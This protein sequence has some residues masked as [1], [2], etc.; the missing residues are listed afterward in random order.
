VLSRERGEVP[1]LLEVF[2]C[3]GRLVLPVLPQ[4]ASRRRISLI[5][6]KGDRLES[7]SSQLGLTSGACI[8]SQGT[9]RMHILSHPN[10]LR[11]HPGTHSTIHPAGATLRMADLAATIHLPD[12]S[13]VETSEAEDSETLT[14]RLV[15]TCDLPAQPYHKGLRI[16]APSNESAPRL[17]A[18]LLVDSGS[19]PRPRLAVWDLI[20]GAFLRGFEADVW[21]LA[22]YHRPSDGRPRIAVGVAGGELVIYDGDDFVVLGTAQSH[23]ETDGV[24][25]L[26][27]VE[28]PGSGATRLVSG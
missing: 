17:L 23:P 22:T 28:I 25:Q 13:P 2:L 16:Y 1:S 14:P 4:I 15:F 21:S 12:L 3:R 7:M 26:A 11:Q 27:A 20:S 10:P 5:A 6:S 9:A 8:Q 18:S 19:T 24:T